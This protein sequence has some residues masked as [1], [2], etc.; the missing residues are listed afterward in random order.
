M[1]VFTFFHFIQ[2]VISVKKIMNN[3][4]LE[5]CEFDFFGLKEG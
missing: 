3:L 5:Y 4:V 2:I 1:R